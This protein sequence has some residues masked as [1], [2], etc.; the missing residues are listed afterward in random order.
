MRNQFQTQKK[1]KYVD[2]TQ[3]YDWILQ[4]DTKKDPKLISVLS[5]IAIVSV[6]SEIMTNEVMVIEVIP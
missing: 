6:A 2:G 1:D 5:F 4:G 3:P